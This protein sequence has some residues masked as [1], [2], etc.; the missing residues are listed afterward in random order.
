[1]EVHISLDFFGKNAEE[2][3]GKVIFNGKDTVGFG[4]QRG[5]IRK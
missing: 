5:D 2:I 1:M 3:A 4:G